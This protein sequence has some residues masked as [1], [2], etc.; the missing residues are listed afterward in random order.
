MQKKCSK[1][2]LSFLL[3]MVLVLSMALLTTGCNDSKEK[4]NTSTAETEVT[5]Q[6]EGGVLGEGDTIF[7]F[8]V[9][10]KEGNE[11][12]FE[13]HTDKQTVGEAL[14][15]LDLIEGE[16]GDYGLFV[17]TVNGITADYDVDGTYWAF[18]VNGEYATSGGDTTT[19]TE[20]DSYSFKVEK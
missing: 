8:T 1:K 3:C 12:E 13:I 6:K 10:D 4:G 14:I 20:G 9:V 16:E 7:Y 2:I 5:A 19:I 15:E 17:K 18:Y 11:T